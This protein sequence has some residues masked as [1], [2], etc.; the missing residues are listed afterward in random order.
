MRKESTTER[1]K[2]PKR[3]TIKSDQTTSSD[4]SIH[5][6][7]HFRP[8]PHIQP[9]RVTFTSHHHRRTRRRPLPNAVSLSDVAT[10]PQKAICGR[11]TTLHHVYS[12]MMIPTQRPLSAKGR[13]KGRR[14]THKCDPFSSKLCRDN[15][16]IRILQT[17]TQACGE[18]EWAQLHDCLYDERLERGKKNWTTDKSRVTKGSSGQRTKKS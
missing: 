7:T 11:K 2:L 1:R 5:S 6:H 17:T 10:P 8:P 9:K 4:V 15:R 18:F 14:M 3:S 12:T 13:G 16:S